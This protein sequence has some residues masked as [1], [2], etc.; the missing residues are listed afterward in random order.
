MFSLFKFF[1]TLTGFHKIFAREGTVNGFLHN[2]EIW[3]KSASP[4]RSGT[5]EFISILLLILFTNRYQ[6]FSGV[7]FPSFLASPM[8]FFFV[9]GGG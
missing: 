3:F 8:S 1:S 9:G 7:G 2:K 4:K 5:P 6:S